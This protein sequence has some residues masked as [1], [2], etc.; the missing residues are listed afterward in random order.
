MRVDGIEIEERAGGQRKA[1]PLERDVAEGAPPRGGAGAEAV[2]RQVAEI[3]D[4]LLFHSSSSGVPFGQNQKISAMATGMLPQITAQP[5]KIEATKATPT[6]NA[7]ASG[8]I[9]G[10]GEASRTSGFAS[11]TVEMMSSR[12]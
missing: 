6:K 11:A 3:G 9:D 1:G 2:G 12:R 7:V 5:V 10:F 8:Q 4:R